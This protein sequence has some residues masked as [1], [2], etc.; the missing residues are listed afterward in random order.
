MAEY[1]DREHLIA[2]NADED[3]KQNGLPINVEI[4]VKTGEETVTEVN[5]LV[6]PTKE[7]W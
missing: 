5:L 1:S 6:K 7:R 3:G 4:D 2:N